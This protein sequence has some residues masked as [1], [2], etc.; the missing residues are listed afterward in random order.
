MREA[1]SE[2]L[3]LF[4]VQMREGKPVASKHGHSVTKTDG[5][6]GGLYTD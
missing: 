2:A 3:K 4:W 6:E 5:G 1:E